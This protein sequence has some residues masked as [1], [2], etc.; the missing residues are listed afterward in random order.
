M[1]N[2]YTPIKQKIILWLDIRNVKYYDFNNIQCIRYSS[3]S[4]DQPFISG[5]DRISRYSFRFSSLKQL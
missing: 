3:L 4:N 5:F 1:N 2:L